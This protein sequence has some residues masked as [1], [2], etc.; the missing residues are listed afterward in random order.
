MNIFSMLL[1]EMPTPELTNI[2]G[3]FIKVLFDG[4]GNYGV[5]VIVFTLILKIALSPLD[6][7]Q[8]LAMRKQSKSMARLKPQM[9]KIQRQYANN[10]EM[11]RVK[12]SELYRKEKVTSSMFASCLPM[13]VTMVVFFVVFGGFNAMVRYQ[14]EMILFKMYEGYESG[15]TNEQIVAHY[16]G[17]VGNQYQFLWIDNIFMPDSWAN[18]VPTFNEYS[19]TSI[20]QIGAS[21]P[22]VIGNVTEYNN[23]M[24]AV[25]SAYNKSSFWNIGKW[26]GYLVLP[27]LSIVTSIFSSKLT[28][29]SAAQQ[30]AVGTEQQQKQ[31]QMTQKMMMLIM[32]IMV[33]VFSV[34]YSAAFSLY[35]F[36]SS[37]FTTVFNLIFNIVAKKIDKKEEEKMLQTTFR[38]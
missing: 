1:T 21:L 19:G 37:L 32:P 33:G 14:N 22:V 26:N 13:I 31:Q 27:I 9:D 34:F 23:L 8:K 25:M 24:G 6:V 16:N 18:I 36:I 38:R 29:N 5:T 28:Q 12:Q 11:L 10:P 2:I 4:I 7:W 15:M 3:K 20:G 17:I 30:A 35:M